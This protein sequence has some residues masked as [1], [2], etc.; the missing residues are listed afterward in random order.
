MLR[1]WACGQR[2][3]TAWE[4]GCAH[5]ESCIWLLLAE[6]VGASLNVWGRALHQGAGAGSCISVCWLRG[7]YTLVYIGRS[8]DREKVE[9]NL[10]QKVK[11]IVMLLLLQSEEQRVFSKGCLEKEASAK[12][13]VHKR[14]MQIWRVCPL[15]I[16]CR[17]NN[18]IY[19]SVKKGR[20][21]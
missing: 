2:C 8:A 20:P 4:R 21:K 13:S 10:N 12:I 16:G 19:L 15:R 11:I 9:V 7:L 14:D 17:G 18:K 6:C 3:V 5:V 1:H